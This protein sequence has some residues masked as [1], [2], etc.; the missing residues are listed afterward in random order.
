MYIPLSV[1]LRIALDS[2]HPFNNMRIK[3]SIQVLSTS[4]SQVHILVHLGWY[5]PAQ[6]PH[7]KAQL[8]YSCWHISMAYVLEYWP[9]S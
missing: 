9:L 3:G 6:T 8:L 5:I 1:L 7:V 4:H 2:V